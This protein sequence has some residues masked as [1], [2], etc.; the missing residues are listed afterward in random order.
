MLVEVIDKETDV[1]DLS[2]FKLNIDGVFQG[3]FASNGFDRKLVSTTWLVCWFEPYY[4]P[5]ARDGSL[6]TLPHN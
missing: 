1:R 2:Y 6:V 5:C 3:G 4:S